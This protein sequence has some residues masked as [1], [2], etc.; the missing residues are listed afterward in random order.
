MTERLDARARRRA[1]KRLQRKYPGVFAR[2]FAEECEL[3][4]IAPPERKVA[5][6]GTRS[7]YNRHRCNGED[8]CDPCREAENR[9]QRERQRR[10][11]GAIK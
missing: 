8:P 9:Y 5:S 4:G 11:R 7:G 10:R 2:Y 3:L 6:C 1:G